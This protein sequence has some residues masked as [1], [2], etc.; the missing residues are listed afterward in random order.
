MPLDSVCLHPTTLLCG[1]KSFQILQSNIQCRDCLPV[2]PLLS[3]AT[4]G[5]NKA[6]IL[7]KLEWI[8]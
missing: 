5:G 7:S 8:P 2:R 4:S 6:K 1:E 3:K